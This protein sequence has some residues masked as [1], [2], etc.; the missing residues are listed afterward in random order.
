MTRGPK[1]KKYSNPK[2]T[3]SHKTLNN[4]TNVLSSQFRENL[5]RSQETLIE[6]VFF[7]RTTAFTLTFIFQPYHLIA[8]K[9]RWHIYLH[10]DQILPGSQ[11]STIPLIQ[12]PWRHLLII[13]GL[14]ADSG[15]TCPFWRHR[16]EAIHCSCSRDYNIAKHIF[17]WLWNIC[18]VLIKITIFGA[19]W[20]L[21]F[22]S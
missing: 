21:L 6:P 20:L 8:P 13:T 7:F 1:H 10:L 18:I 9:F 12:H 17:R 16:L 11:K 15:W 19:L 22:S 14:L 3:F 2:S 5:F 4:G